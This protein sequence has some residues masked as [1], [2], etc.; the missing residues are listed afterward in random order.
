MRNFYA[1]FF[2]M[3]DLLGLLISGE[4]VHVV[5]DKVIVI[6]YFYL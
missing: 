1:A 3:N 4:N 2:H 5:Q 6:L